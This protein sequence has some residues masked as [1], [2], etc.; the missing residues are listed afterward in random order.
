MHA[1]AVGFDVVQAG[2][3]LCAR[4]K[5]AL[6]LALPKRQ[7]RLLPHPLIGAERYS[8]EIEVFCYS[9]YGGLQ[10]DRATPAI[11]VRRITKVVQV[12]PLTLGYIGVVF[13]HNYASLLLRLR[14][15]LRVFAIPR[16]CTPS[17]PSH[18]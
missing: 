7:P 12:L 13:S 18:A 11:S 2:A 16:P 1:R 3:W 14:R 9:S 8:L 17:F 5:S 15:L 6:Y 10:Y 4:M